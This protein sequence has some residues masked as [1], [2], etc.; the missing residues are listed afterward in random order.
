MGKHLNRRTGLTLAELIVC[1]AI[2]TMAFTFTAPALNKG[3][4]GVDRKRCENNLRQLSLAMHAFANNNGGFPPMAIA[5]QGLPNN[6]PGPGA[7]WDNHSWYSLIGPYIGEPE[8]VAT[9]NFTRSM[10]DVSN[11]LARRGGLRLKVHSCPADIGL[12]RN[13]WNSANWARVRS[14]YVANAGNTNYGQSALS[15]VPFLGA[16]FA[17]GVAT[18]LN[19][20][21]D[22]LS[23]TLLVSEVVV[24]PETLATWG[25]AYSDVQISIGGQTFTGFNPP[26]S[27]TPDGIG[28]GR[29]GNL[30]QT[31]ANAAYTQQGIPIPIAPTPSGPLSTYIAPRSKHPGGFNASLCD[32]SAGFIANGI[33]LAVWRALS[34]AR[35]ADVTMP[36]AAAS[37][38][39]KK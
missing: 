12:Q 22:G 10:S 21:T 9:I 8:W 24:F 3:R 5:W 15:G 26:N 13:E 35:G 2:A 1:G 16:P 27:N 32:G 19:T 33:D 6:P 7:W 20:I 31:A 37:H 34:S 4:A 36:P 18:L 28:Y 25:S 17:G 14:N 29:N 38:V 30:G 23:N 39:R 11:G